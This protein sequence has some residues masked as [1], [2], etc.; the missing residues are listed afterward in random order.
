MALAEKYQTSITGLPFAQARIERPLT[1]RPNPELLNEKLSRSSTK[2][3]LISEL[4]TASTGT[5]LFFIDGPSYASR[6]G[7]RQVYLGSCDSTDYVLAIVASDQ[8]SH[9]NIQRWISLREAFAILPELQTELIVEAQAISNWIRTE[10]F[11][12][13]CGSEVRASTFGWGQRCVENEHEL[14]PRTDPAI[15]ASVID[16]QDRILLGANANFR[17]DMYSVLAGFVE[18]GESLESAVR[19]EIFEESGV[20]VGE[21]AY[22]GSQP[23]PLPRSLMLGFAAEALSEDLTPDGAEIKDLRWFSRDELRDALES[24][25][26]E[27]P[28]GVSIAHALIRS[29]YGESL[30]EAL[31]K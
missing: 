10:R 24:G 22:R 12:P 20:H 11:C 29:W 25:T 7:E 8:Y 4:G 14:F 16:Q 30:P 26:I 18:A 1:E 3:M 9:L 6:D 17:S 15:I 5:E 28:R 2:V 31:N 27:I 23:W 13:Q 21:V 19:R